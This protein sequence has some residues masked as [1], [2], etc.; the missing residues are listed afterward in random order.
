MRPRPP[1]TQEAPSG[2]TA[3]QAPRPH[4]GL[5]GAHEPAQPTRRPEEAGAGAQAPVH[6]GPPRSHGVGP[7]EK[8]P[9]LPCPHPHPGAAKHPGSGL[10]LTRSGTSLRPLSDSDS[11]GG[12]L[13]TNGE[14]CRSRK[15]SWP[16]LQP[17]ALPVRE[18][19]APAQRAAGAQGRVCPYPMALSGS[20]QSSDAN[21]ANFAQASFALLLKQNLFIYL[22]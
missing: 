20:L 3:S 18:C 22:F 2:C 11:Q 8:K 7:T 4:G 12:Q 6:L 13:T 17:W 5:P 1:G 19:W 15:G 16:H 9:P 10:H 14:G 21:A